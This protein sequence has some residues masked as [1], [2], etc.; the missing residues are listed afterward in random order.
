MRNETRLSR[1]R[2]SSRHLSTSGNNDN[3]FMDL[4]PLANPLHQPMMMQ[5][6]FDGQGWHVGGGN[7]DLQQQQ[8]HAIQQFIAAQVGKARA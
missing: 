5:M 1:F 3:A 6:H 8:D 4:G 2:L 7:H